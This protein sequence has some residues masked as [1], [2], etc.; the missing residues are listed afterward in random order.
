MD[1]KNYMEI[2]TN[3]ELKQIH[4]V[5]ENFLNYFNAFV[6]QSYEIVSNNR[7]VAFCITLLSL[8]ILFS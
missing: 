5:N 1:K 8:L 3:G 4:L 7:F 6:Q 2:N